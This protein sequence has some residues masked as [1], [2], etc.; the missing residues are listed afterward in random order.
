MDEHAGRIGSNLWR[1]DQG[2]IGSKPGG[3]SR[4]GPDCVLP[5]DGKGGVRASAGV[6]ESHPDLCEEGCGWRKGISVVPTAGSWGPH[7]GARTFV[8]HQDRGIIGVDGRDLF[9]G[10]GAAAV[11]GEV[12]WPCR[13][14]DALPAA[15]CGFDCYGE[16]A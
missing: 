16:V 9:F 10:K 1:E 4:G 11:A 12:A 2:G 5:A 13:Y 3:G 6:R 15:L 7:R 14:R 8:S